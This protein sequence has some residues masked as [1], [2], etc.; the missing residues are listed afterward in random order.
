[1]SS[2]I[3]LECHVFFIHSIFSA[4]ITKCFL[5]RLW[6]TWF[7]Y[8]TNHTIFGYVFIINRMYYPML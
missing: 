3:F 1:M 8:R 6:F 5:K 2:F 7:T 4:F